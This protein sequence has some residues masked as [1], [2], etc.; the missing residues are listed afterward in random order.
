MNATYD[1]WKQ[2]TRRVTLYL[3]KDYNTLRQSANQA[4][5][6][7]IY[8]VKRFKFVCLL[9]ERLGENGPSKRL[10]PI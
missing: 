8:Y 1:A 3:H 7:D 10:P 5:K 6:F 9:L 4:E 2:K